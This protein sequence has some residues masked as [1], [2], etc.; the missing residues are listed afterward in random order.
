MSAAQLL[1]ELT[2]LGVRVEAHGGRLRY[3]PKSAVTPDLIDRMKAH[4]TELLQFAGKEY[5]PAFPPEVV[6]AMR[7]ANA[8]F[9]V[10]DE[11]REE[12]TAIILEGSGFDPRMCPRCGST[13]RVE[14]DIH[15]GKSS[16]IDCVDCERFIQFN[17]WHGRWLLAYH[18][19]SLDW[20]ADNYRR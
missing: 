13:D 16:R 14:V 18:G 3:S 10:D 9:V 5:N 15:G 12:R 7:L 11:D 6:A 19:L 17:R 8:E 2:Q 1:A 20:L 4:K